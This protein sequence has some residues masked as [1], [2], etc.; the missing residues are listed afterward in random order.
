MRS[1]LS[2]AEMVGIT[3]PRA[4]VW[5]GV[6]LIVHLGLAVVTIDDVR[7]PVPTLAA[8]VCVAIAGVVLTLPATDPLPGIRS[9]VVLEC[10]ALSTVLVA[11][12]LPSEPVVGY[13][14]WHLGAN[15]FVLLFLGM[16]GRVGW[17]W[18]GFC[19]VVGITA[20]WTFTDGRG[21]L[22]QLA[23]LPNQ[24]G[25]L[26]V[27]SMLAL[28]LR[29]T[30]RRISSLHAEQAALASSESATR[31]AASER[32]RQAA[33]LN[34]IARPA[35]ERIAALE[36]YTD[37]ERESWL[38]LE[39]TIRDRLRAPALSS[40]EITEAATLARERGV[41]VTLFDDSAGALASE[42]DRNAI[43][44]AIIAELAA[45]D[46]GRLTG[47][48]LPPG[49]GRLATILVDDERGDSRSIDVG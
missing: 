15:T 28:G 33:R 47:R 48:V 38:R 24:V 2:V 42:E 45:M 4:G 29:F 41:E 20:I 6:A 31:A 14:T 39:A 5:L 10:V 19:V 17:A 13:A 18:L 21:S 25:T 8:W 9:L 1:D 49:R 34:A 40:A 3:R 44:A 30:S 37:A 23:L 12:N 7:H 36:P 32:A 11:W 26:L 35:L 43:A 16:R 27:G 46:S 22:Y